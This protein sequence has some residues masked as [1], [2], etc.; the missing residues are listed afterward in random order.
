MELAT[1]QQN[2]RTLKDMQ[3][4]FPDNSSKFFNIPENSCFPVHFPVHFPF[5]YIPVRV[6]TMSKSFHSSTD[7][8]KYFYNSILIGFL[9]LHEF[10]KYIY[11][12]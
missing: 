7:R 6:A 11:E 8:N 3:E 4:N 1:K 12:I 10:G 5:Q 9:Y 2:P